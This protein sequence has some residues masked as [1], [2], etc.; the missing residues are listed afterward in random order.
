LH[1]L[2]LG[3]LASRFGDRWTGLLW[4]K[5]FHAA[6]VEALRHVHEGRARGE[7]VISVSEGQTRFPPS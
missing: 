5:P 4:W 6:D 2:V 3:P 7:V 1:W